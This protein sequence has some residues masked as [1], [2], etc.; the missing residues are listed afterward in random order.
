MRRRQRLG[1][2]AALLVLAALLPLASPPAA[3]EGDPR[4]ERE[5]VR[6]ERAAAAAELDSLR[7]T[8]AEV[9]A[10]LDA[11]EA[12]VGQERAR[13]DDAKR[14]AARAAADAAEAKA[15]E[16]KTAA[17][18]A[19]LEQRMTEVAVAAYVRAGAPDGNPLLTSASP[20]EAAVRLALLDATSTSAADVTDRLR[21]LHEDLGVLRAEADAAAARAAAQRD[22]VAQRVDA[23]E[24]AE[25][26]QRAVV[27]E[28]D[29]RIESKLAEAAA[30]EQLDQQLGR[31]IAQQLAAQQARLAAQTQNVQR[32]ITTGPARVVA[33][34]TRANVPLATVRG[35][36]V[37]RDIADDLARL[38]D[39]A[40]A[41]AVSFGGGGYRDPEDQW[42][43]RRANCPD[44]ANSPPSSCRPPTARPG[45]SMHEQGLAVDFTYDGA[46]IS[47]RSNPGFRWLSANAGRFGFRNLPSEPWHWSINGQ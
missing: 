46:L 36:T 44:P 40:E 28:V 12:N 41:D 33:G 13:L 1:G 18:I 21:A 39:A 6:R 10:A 32:P 38:L 23:L 3:G 9:E 2:A 14:T 7:D 26:Q 43:L 4:R 19:G 27:A 16:Q 25:E 11:L 30:L 29:E 17:E 20:N 37:H 31:Q 35:I 45:Q 8:D 42:R 34:P 24:R 5:R 47:S 15:V 22:E